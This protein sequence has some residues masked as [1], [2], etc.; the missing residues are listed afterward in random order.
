MSTPDCSLPGAGRGAGKL[1]H[2]DNPPNHDVP[3]SWSPEDTADLQH[4]G[5]QTPGGTQS[6]LGH[7]HSSCD[8]GKSGQQ[9]CY[10]EPLWHHCQRPASTFCVNDTAANDEDGST[11]RL[12]I[13]HLQRAKKEGKNFY[14][15]CGFHRPH[16]PY[17]STDATWGGYD[18]KAITAA[19]HRTMHPSVPDLA[20]IV[21]FGIGLENGTSYKWDPRNAPVPVEVQLAVRRHYYAAISWMDHLVG[22]VLTAVEQLGFADNTVVI[23]HADQCVT[24]VASPVPADTPSFT[25]LR[26][27]P[28]LCPAATLWARVASGRRRCSSR[29]RRA[30]RC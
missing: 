10:Y 3:L 12:T 16:A 4:L 11:M 26:A 22:G 20:M 25:H 9:A 21:N 13:A 23:F 15:G 1:Y 19:K 27:L 6:N 7:N 5:P 30:C 18:G 8:V 17:I 29:T 24:A 28:P 2:T 14:I